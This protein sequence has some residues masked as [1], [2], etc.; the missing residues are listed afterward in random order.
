MRTRTHT[1]WWDVDYIKEYEPEPV[2]QINP[3]DAADLGISEGDT[4]RLYNDFGDVTLI[5][6]I[7]AGLPRNMLAS[8]R[9]FHSFE[10]KDGHLANLSCSDYNQ[11]IPNSAFNDVAVAIEKVRA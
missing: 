4:V 5:A 7:N 3:L 1:Q 8:K 2:V 6:A 9:S 11:M 10:Y